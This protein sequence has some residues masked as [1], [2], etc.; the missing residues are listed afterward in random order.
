MSVAAPELSVP[1]PLRTAVEILQK[2][3]MPGVT[4]DSVSG[5]WAYVMLPEIRFPAATYPPPNVRPVWIRLP[6]QFP[7]ALPHGVVTKEPITKHDGTNAKGHNVG[8]DMCAPVAGK[9]GS[10]YYSWTWSGELG[11][12]PALNSP[13]DITKV[14]A[15]VERRIRLS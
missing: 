4:V 2:K 10:F 5:N 13:E 9:G 12:G 15:W 6:I 14:V 7:L 1:E 11:Q 8:G 3:L